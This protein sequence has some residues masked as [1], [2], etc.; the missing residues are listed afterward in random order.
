VSSVVVVPDQDDFPPTSGLIE[1]FPRQ[2][3]DG[4][5]LRIRNTTPYTLWLLSPD[6]PDPADQLKKYDAEAGIRIRYNTPPF[7]IYAHGVGEVPVD[8]DFALPRGI[9]MSPAGEV[10]KKRIRIR[11][12]SPLALDI[13][14][15]SIKEARDY[16]DYECALN[17][18][19]EARL[20]GAYL[21]DGVPS[22]DGASIYVPLAE[23]PNATNAKILKIDANNLQTTAQ[24][25]V[26][27]RH[28]FLVPNSVAVLEDR[29]LALF[30]REQMNIFNDDLKS[31]PGLSFSQFDYNILTNLKGS[32][33][34]IFTVGMKENSQ[35]GFTYSYAAD[36]WFFDN[37]RLHHYT[38]GWVSSPR[39]SGEPSR[40]PGAPSWVGPN[41]ISPM[42]V[43][44]GVARA[45]CVDGGVIGSDIRIGWKQIDVGLPGTG[46]E[47]AIHVDPTEDVIFCAHSK[48]EAVPGLMVSRINLANPSDKLTI[49]LP[50]TVWNMVTDPKPPKDPN[51]EYYRARAVSLLATPDALFVSHA[52]KIYVLDKTRLTQRQSIQLRLPS[53]LIQVRRGKAPGD[54]HPTYGP[55]PDCYFI[56]A[57]GA[58]YSGDGQ[59]V[60]AE[61]LGKTCETVLY[62]IALPVGS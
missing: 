9:E 7:S 3:T 28:I 23:P 18:Q 22:N 48:R 58:K 6:A 46:R 52:K 35:G 59:A 32:G 29:I 13:D 30:N 15:V 24:A 50:G 11:Q 44:P 19:V 21:G 53:R 34:Y 12:N 1:R 40:V 61:E 8:V 56:W 20:R 57:I 43:R 45:I 25:S 5:R 16:D 62:K 55:P 54:N 42:D 41:T 47:Q 39:T 60:R 4:I 10:Q 17:Y 38:Y 31:K 33:P 27:G 14:S 51:L 49:E 26:T 37:E 2:L 36:S